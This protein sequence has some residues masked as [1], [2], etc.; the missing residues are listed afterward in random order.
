MKCELYIRIPSRDDSYMMMENPFNMMCQLVNDLQLR[1]SERSGLWLET[2]IETSLQWWFPTF[3]EAEDMADRA[4][5]WL[6]EK[7]YRLGSNA[8]VKGDGFAYA[9][10]REVPENVAE[11]LKLGWIE[12]NTEGIFSKC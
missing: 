10:A 8:D 9:F 6:C 3:L 1:I 7:G 5:T 4:V 12:P 2:A 11:V